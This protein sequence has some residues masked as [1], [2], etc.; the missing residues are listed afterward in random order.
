MSTYT[1]KASEITRSWHVVDAEDL[2]LGRVAWHLWH[3]ALLAITAAA[4]LAVDGH[5]FVQ[6]RI[7]LLDIFVMWWALLAFLFLLLDRE[8]GRRRLAERLALE[9][10]S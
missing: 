9:T 8:Q 10:C 3:N 5:H 7:G 4:L 2:V 6:S 1:P